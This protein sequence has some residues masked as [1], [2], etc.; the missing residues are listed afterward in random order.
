MTSQEQLKESPSIELHAH[1]LIESSEI[2]GCD[3]DSVSSGSKT[4]TFDA[5]SDEI[6]SYAEKSDYTNSSEIKDCWKWY[7]T[8]NDRWMHVAVQLIQGWEPILANIVI[9]IKNYLIMY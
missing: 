3:S 6:T 7:Q 4:V 5:E 1:S 8:T 2:D 9:E